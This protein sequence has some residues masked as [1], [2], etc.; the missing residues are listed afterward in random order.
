MTLQ[1]RESTT[2]SKNVSLEDFVAIQN[3][4]GR[5]QWLVDS[6]DSE[7]WAGLWTEDG[8]FTGGATQPFIGREELKKVPAWVKTGWNGALRHLS[9]SFCVEYGAGKDEA[10][11]R[12]YNLVTTWNGA[13]PKL[14]TMALSE[15]RLLRRNGEWM[16]AANHVTTLI[17]PLA[18]GTTQ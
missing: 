12:Y 5:Y 18:Y 8:A 3:L 1:I 11:A 9:G 16:I 2:M 14:S 4:I 13:Q 7:G 15:M 17:P 6:G 10:V